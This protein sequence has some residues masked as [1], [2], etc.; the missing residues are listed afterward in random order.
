MRLFEFTN[1]EEQLKLLQLIFDTSF[2]TIRQQAELQA[3]EKASK[4]SATKFK[5]KRVPKS[6]P[7]IKRLPPPKLP[8]PNKPNSTTYKPN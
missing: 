6:P 1:A 4:A 5:P 3:K 2:S 8:I 7:S